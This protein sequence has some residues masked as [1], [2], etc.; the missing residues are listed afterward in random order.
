MNGATFIRCSFIYLLDSLIW[1]QISCAPSFSAAGNLR[2]VWTRITDLKHYMDLT[3]TQRQSFPDPD[4]MNDYDYSAVSFLIFLFPLHPHSA[5][6]LSL[7]HTL[8]DW[9]ALKYLI[10]V[11]GNWHHWFCYPVM[12]ELL[13]TNY[14]RETLAAISTSPCF[15]I[16]APESVFQH[17]LFK[18][19]KRDSFEMVLTDQRW[20]RG[21]LHIICVIWQNLIIKGVWVIVR[22]IHTINI[23][24]GNTLV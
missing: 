21:H 20:V 23:T 11:D 24:Y 18:L 12:V 16:W 3:Q 4:V 5:S 6:P 19:W 14:T 8:S 1:S 17:C 22:Y 9:V 2:N 13:W 7:S 10:I 15:R